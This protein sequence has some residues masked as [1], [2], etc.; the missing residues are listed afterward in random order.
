MDREIAVSSLVG[1]WPLVLIVPYVLA[2][3]FFARLAIAGAVR[4]RATGNMTFADHVQRA[5]DR[6]AFRM[7]SSRLVRAWRDAMLLLGAQLFIAHWPVAAWKLRTIVRMRPAEV[8][9][10]FA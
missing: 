9:A 1:D 5:G 3:L 6:A 10:Y 7:E 4:G 8:E 2:G